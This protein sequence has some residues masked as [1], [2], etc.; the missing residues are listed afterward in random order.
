MYFNDYF[1][2]DEEFTFN[3]MTQVNFYDKA[4]SLIVTGC[5]PWTVYEDND[6]KVSMKT[7]P[8]SIMDFT[9]RRNSFGKSTITGK[10]CPFTKSH[11]RVT[12]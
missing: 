7:M 10:F 2:G 6:Y 3:D 12:V 1:I 11:Y 9:I 5:Q 4:K 8:I